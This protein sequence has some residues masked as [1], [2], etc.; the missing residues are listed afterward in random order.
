MPVSH[1]TTPWFGWTITAAVVGISRP[2]GANATR[3]LVS[4]LSGPPLLLLIRRSGIHPP[5]HLPLA[6][7]EASAAW[8]LG[9]AGQSLSREGD[10]L[11]STTF[12]RSTNGIGLTDVRHCRTSAK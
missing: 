9:R 3:R 12:L 1:S 11:G 7:R 6:R 8:S 2:S 10:R 4:T 5:S